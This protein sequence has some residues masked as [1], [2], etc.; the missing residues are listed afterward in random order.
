MVQVTK[1]IPRRQASWLIRQRFR[2]VEHAV[3]FGS[4]FRLRF[5]RSLYFFRT[6]AEI[7]PKVGHDTSFHAAFNS[8]S[9]NQKTIRRILITSSHKDVK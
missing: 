3:R 9:D 7:L 5:H 8:V 6:N 2:F 1:N 4:S